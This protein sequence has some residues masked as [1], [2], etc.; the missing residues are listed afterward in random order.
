M[1][2][3]RLPPRKFVGKSVA[4]GDCLLMH[5]S[6]GLRENHGCARTHAKQELPHFH[7]KLTFKGEGLIPSFSFPTRETK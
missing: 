4:I 6:K 2:E 1:D 3:M 5:E 7:A